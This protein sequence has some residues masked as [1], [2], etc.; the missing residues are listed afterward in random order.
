M[1]TIS[2]KKPVE[3]RPPQFVDSR[4][5][6][7][8]V[9]EREVFVMATRRT[10]ESSSSRGQSVSEVARDLNIHPNMLRKPEFCE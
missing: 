9:H 10:A 3:R 1:Q 5:R 7:F 6:W 4:L 2:E 8:I